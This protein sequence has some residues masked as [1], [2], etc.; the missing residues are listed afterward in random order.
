[1]KLLLFPFIC[2]GAAITAVVVLCAALVL[3]V[4]GAVFGV[5]TGLVGAIFGAGTALLAAG[6]AIAVA[7]FVVGLVLAPLWLPIL[8]IVGIV[9]LCRRG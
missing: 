2:L 5:I 1:M 3:P 9:K 4:L 6:G 7:A 8:A